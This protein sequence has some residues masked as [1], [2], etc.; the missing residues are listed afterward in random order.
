MRKYF[1]AIAMTALAEAA[2]VVGAS[3]QDARF[4]V[5]HVSNETRSEMSFY[6]TWVWHSGRVERGWSLIKIGPGQTRTVHYSYDGPDRKSPDLIVVFDSDRNSGARWEKVKLAR[7]ASIDFHDRGTGFTYALRYDNDR[8]EF[9]SLR[10]TNGGSV[11]VLDRNA[12]PPRL[13]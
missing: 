13:N 12:A 2:F 4:A 5:V 3:A 7:A 10:P 6:H 11:T 9:A 8:Q 1:V